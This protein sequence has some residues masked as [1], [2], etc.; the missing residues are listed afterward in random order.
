MI[1]HFLQIFIL[2]FNLA[3]S[4]NHTIY[5]KQSQQL[6]RSGQEYVYHTNSNL[7]IGWDNYGNTADQTCSAIIPGWVYPGGS[8]LNFNCR[9]GYWIIA[10]FGGSLYYHPDKNNHPDLCLFHQINNIFYSLLLEI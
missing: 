2:I 7:W 8:G 4:Q 6:S 3:Y 9:A 10:D 1:K 5:N